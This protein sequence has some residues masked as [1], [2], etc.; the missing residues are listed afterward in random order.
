VEAVREV[1]AKPGVKAVIFKSPCIAV[2]KP[3]KQCVIDTEKCIT[4]KKCIR[5]LGCPAITVNDGRVV[6][7]PSLC[8]GCGICKSVCPVGAIGGGRNE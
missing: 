6:I 7:E 8:F 3:E 4:C 1:A 2:S 5:E